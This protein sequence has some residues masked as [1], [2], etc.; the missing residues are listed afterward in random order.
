MQ[1]ALREVIKKLIRSHLEDGYIAMG[2][3]LTAVGWVGGTLPEMYE[4]DGMIELSMADVAGGGFAV[5]AALA[6]KRPIYIIR[7]QG[8]G[9][10]NLPIILNYACKSKEIWNR[11]CPLLVR[12][13]AMEGSIGPVAGSS[14]HS[15]AYRMPGIKIFSPMSGEEYRTM[16]NEFMSSD[17]VFYASEH[18]GSFANDQP[19][20]DFLFP[21]PDFVVVAISVTRF[22]A[23]EAV[24]NLNSNG[25][26][27]S[28]INI[29]RLK[30]FQLDQKQISVLSNSK[31][32]I[33]LLDDDYEYGAVASIGLQISSLLP[34]PKRL[35]LMG[36]KD[37]SAGFSKNSD[38]LP[39]SV[40]EI[41]DRVLKLIKVEQEC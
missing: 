40:K 9:W 12:A 27:V 22:N 1:Q 5:G 41:Q 11:P 8:F 10:F 14:H 35:S 25:I 17:E 30:P 21:K 26:K 29:W 37:K 36:L 38:N 2:Q 3:C 20:E 31:F 33:L 32:G 16:Y 13:I 4:E 34:N 24:I 19:I 28:L 15:L 7:Y 39:P 23:R 18:R 6:G